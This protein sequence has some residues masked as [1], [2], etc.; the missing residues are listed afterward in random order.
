M[1][2]EEFDITKFGEAVDPVDRAADDWCSR[3]VG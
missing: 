2:D 3:L 1:A